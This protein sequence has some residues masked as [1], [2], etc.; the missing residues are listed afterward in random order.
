MGPV[1]RCMNYA[2]A[3]LLVKL[4]IGTCQKCKDSLESMPIVV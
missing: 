2:A 3:R 1:S 4:A